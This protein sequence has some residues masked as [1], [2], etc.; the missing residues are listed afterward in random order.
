MKKLVSAFSAVCLFLPLIASAQKS[1]SAQTPSIIPV[2]QIHAGMRGVAYTV[3]Q[4]VKP[5][6][7]DV[8]VLG[9][10]HNV[11]G[12]KGDVIL[13]RLHGQKVEYT[14]VVAGMSGRRVYLD[15]KLAGALDFRIGEFSKGPIGGGQPLAHIPE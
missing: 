14:G 9:V 2:S 12:P 8:E 7:M 3:F 11:N 4:G 6:S 5:E 13:V 10:L 15:G 1:D